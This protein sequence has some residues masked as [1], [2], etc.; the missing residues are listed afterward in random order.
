MR[1]I[2]YSL[3]IA[4]IVV[5]GYFLA[6]PKSESVANTVAAAPIAGKTLRLVGEA[7]QPLAPAPKSEFSSAPRQ[8]CYVLGPYKDDLDARHVQARA[9]ALSLTGMI[10]SI[11]VGEQADIEYWVHVPPRIDRAA[12]MATL[13]ELQRRSIDSYIITQGDLAEGISLGLFHSLDSA[14]KLKAE[15]EVYE[16][17]VDI[18]E[19]GKRQLEYW[20][21]IREVAQLT[22]RMRERV[23]A[24][25]HGVEWKLV[26]CLN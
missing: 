11:G 16:F 21:E 23:Q 5:A 17:P 13:K 19:M 6:Q 12:A 3:V 22:E 15:V 18:L 1:W 20:V 2:F 7:E 9:A 24:G 10:N 14:K 4:N 26:E 25:D 8:L